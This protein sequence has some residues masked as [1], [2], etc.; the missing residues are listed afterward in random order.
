[1]NRRELFRRTL[2]AIAAAVGHPLLPTKLPTPDRIAFHPNAFMLTMGRPV[3]PMRYDILYGISPANFGV[4]F[5][6]NEVL[7][8]E[9]TGSFLQYLDREKELA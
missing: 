2:G 6:W 4:D 8:R 3:T 5:E 1:M 7:E 9:S